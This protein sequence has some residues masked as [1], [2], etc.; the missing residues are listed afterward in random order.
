MEEQQTEAGLGH[1]LPPSEGMTQ[2]DVIR[3]RLEQESIGLMARAIEL[4]QAFD[5][6]P[7]KVESEDQA[8]KFGDFIKQI[9]GH[10]KKADAARVASK[11]PYLEGGRAVD[12]FFK[13]IIDP[14]K[15]AKTTLE[16]RL[17]TYLRAKEAE[18]RRR[19]EEE[20][21]RAEE[22]ARA[23]AAEMKSED[24]LDAAV[25]AEVQAQDAAKAAEAN[26][27][28]MSRTRGDMGSVSSLR[29]TWAFEV[30]DWD[31][32]PLDM[33]R[34]HLPKSAIEQAIRSFIKAGGRSIDGVRIFEKHSAVVR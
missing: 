15:K 6:A 21:Q 14:L 12:G 1:N 22:E 19:R 16:G 3:A 20:R 2:A 4:Q 9:A 26:A 10:V 33:L 28:E 31:R 7:D 30:D 8:E 34:A 13:S 29:T 27:A 32:I 18:E 25:E 11:E 17:G 23:K 5:R 24:D